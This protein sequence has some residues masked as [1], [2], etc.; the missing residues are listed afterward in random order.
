MTWISR[1]LGGSA[2][3]P[4]QA[5]AK[6]AAAARSAAW[7]TALRNDEIPDFVQARLAEAGAGKV[8]WIST[9]T[10]SELLIARS[11]GMRPIATVTGTCWYQYGRS[12]TEGHATG[13]Q[14]ALD[15]MRN[16]ALACG[17]NAVV[18]VKMRTAGG[19][20]SGSMDFSL[21]GTAIRVDGLP[22]SVEPVIATVPALEFVRLLEMGIVPTG[23]AVGA[24]Y[25]W[26]NDPMKSLGGSWTMNNQP[27]TTLGQFWERVRRYAHANLKD[28]ARRQGN[29][30]LAHTQFSQLLK[31]EG[32]QNI[33]DSYLGRHIVIGTVVDIRP[34]DGVPHHIQTVVDMRDD[35]SPLN[36]GATSPS[37]NIYGTNDREGAI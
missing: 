33:P 37:Q 25:E 10:P 8:P 5:E 35:L 12:W 20:L 2:A 4:E 36:G 1:L 29:G 22:P 19:G 16:E 7:E 26:L 24:C 30:V 6:A 28:D 21:L 32:D 18:D 14:S 15:R 34:G 13:W 17:A 3:S 27:L 9:M 11:H 31:R 23:L